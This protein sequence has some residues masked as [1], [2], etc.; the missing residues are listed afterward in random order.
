MEENVPT[1][2]AIEPH[3]LLQQQRQQARKEALKSVWIGAGLIGL[4]V[5]FVLFDALDFWD[6][7]RSLL[8]IVGGAILVA[9]VWELRQVKALTLADLV[10]DEQA[11]AFAALIESVKPTYTWVILICLITVMLAQL[12][13]GEKQSIAA[14]GLVKSAVWQGQWWRL[15]TAATLHVNFLHIWMNGQALVNLGKL[16]EASAHRAHLS[17]VFLVSAFG[18]SCFSLL[19]LPHTTSVGASGGLMGLV[20]F[21]AVLGYRRRERV[22]KRFFKAIIL[23]ICLV[24]LVGLIGFA[25]IDN[26]AHFGGLIAGVGCGLIM[27]KSGQAELPVEADL[28]SRWLGM[29]SLLAIAGIALLSIVIILRVS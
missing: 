9:G 28:A 25:V 22:P 13:A 14:A 27:V 7:F 24:G 26:A 17:L 12:I 5:L 10:V 1:E 3:E 8:F 11:A 6:M 21:L 29:L 23:N 2:Q 16:I 18:G 20:G 19:L 4:H 15:L